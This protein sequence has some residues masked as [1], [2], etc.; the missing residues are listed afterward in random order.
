MK[1]RKSTLKRFRS[2]VKFI[3]KFHN[4]PLL[5][6]YRVSCIL[7]SYRGYLKLGN[8]YRSYQ[9]IVKLVNTGHLVEHIG[10][11]NKRLLED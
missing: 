5:D 11:T 10:D 1:V 9:N 7:N 8:C 4:T 2:R 6:K 3:N